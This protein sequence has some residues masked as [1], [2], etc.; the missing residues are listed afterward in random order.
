MHQHQI[1]MTI[2]QSICEKFI[3]NLKFDIF[4]GIVVVVDDGDGG[5]G[6]GAAAKK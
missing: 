3:M 1:R 2:M 5:G 4:F 6:G